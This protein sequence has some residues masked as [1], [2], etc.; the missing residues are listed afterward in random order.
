MDPAQPSTPTSKPDNTLKTV[1]IIVGVVAGF[2][3][4]AII[5]LVVFIFLLAMTDKKDSD[6]DTNPQSKTTVSQSSAVTATGSIVTSSCFSHTLPK[7]YELDTGSKACSSSLN[8]S[9]G[10]SLTS[11]QV[12]GIT[13]T[14]TV[15]EGIEKLKGIL[16][17]NNFKIYSSKEIKVGNLSV[18]EV[19][20]ED[21]YGLLRAYYYIPDPKPRF[22]VN[23]KLISSYSVEGYIYNTE[24]KATV[25]SVVK[26]FVIAE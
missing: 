13:D 14:G 9:G 11:I 25:E 21:S 1:L 2:F 26:S 5:S 23:G 22:T 12:R 15:S 8:I 24:L 10:D 18:G 19:D 4:L 7:G 17:E 16:T 20:F 6:R 3:I